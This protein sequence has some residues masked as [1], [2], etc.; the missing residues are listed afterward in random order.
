VSEKQSYQELWR[1]RLFSGVPAAAGA[2]GTS[3]DTIFVWMR[4]GS[5][6]ADGVVRKVRAKRLGNR[7]I[8]IGETLGAVLDAL[9]DWEPTAPGGVSPSPVAHAQRAKAAAMM[10]RQPAA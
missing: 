7:N 5:K 1:E 4:I 3:T 8:V 2:A 10:L 9:P 6:G